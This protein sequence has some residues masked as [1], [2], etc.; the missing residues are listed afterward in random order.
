MQLKHKDVQKDGTGRVKLYPEDEEDM[1]HAYNLINKG[2]RVRSTTVR[3]G[4]LS[5]VRWS[6]VDAD[7]F[8][9]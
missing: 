2:D 4:K 3:C 1:W 9:Q 6:W 8:F 5:I 7:Q